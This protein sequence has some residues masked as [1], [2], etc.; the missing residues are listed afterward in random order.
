VR[1]IRRNEECLAFAHDVIDDP[2]AF[3]DAHFDVALE[4]VKILFGIDEMEIVPRVGARDDHHEKIAPVIKITVA[5]RRLEQVAVLF[6]PL[7]QINR[8]QYGWR[9]AAR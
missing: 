9:D 7:V 4:L 8:R 1:N 5:D 3:A 6:D 2:L